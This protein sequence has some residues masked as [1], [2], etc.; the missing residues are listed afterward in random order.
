MV[1]QTVNSAVESNG[2]EA[3]N[4]SAAVAHNL[5]QADKVQNLQGNVT[6][7]T[8]AHGGAGARGRGDPRR[9]VTDDMWTT[10]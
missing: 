9:R 7:A 10:A 8:E 4:A 1:T 5:D 3:G 2:V 6:A